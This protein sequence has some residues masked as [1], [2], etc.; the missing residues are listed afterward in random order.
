MGERAQ[1][2]ER[3]FGLEPEFAHLPDAGGGVGLEEFF[4]EADADAQRD[5]ALL[6]AVVQIAFDLR[7][8]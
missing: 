3:A 2:V 1:F 5:Q 8:L 7:A 4:G 6:G